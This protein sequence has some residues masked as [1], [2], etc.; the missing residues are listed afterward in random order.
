VR[1]GREKEI[2][3][4]KKKR[5]TE[6]SEKTGGKLPI[7]GEETAQDKANAPCLG[8]CDKRKKLWSIKDC[9]HPALK[10]RGVRGWEEANPLL[11]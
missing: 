7:P 6:K 9:P 8:V 11:R 10:N 1:G 3:E 2:S 5:T 4:G